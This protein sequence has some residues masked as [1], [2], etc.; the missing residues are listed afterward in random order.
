[1]VNFKILQKRKF[2]QES[3]PNV[4]QKG[5]SKATVI[6]RSDKSQS[7]AFTRLFY[8]LEWNSIHIQLRLFT[9][10]RSLGSAVE[11]GKNVLV[12]TE[13]VQ[14]DSGQLCTIKQRPR[15]LIH[16]HWLSI[17][18]RINNSLPL[19]IKSL[20]IIFKSIYHLHKILN[21]LGEVN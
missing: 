18:G 15:W 2:S 13:Q 11:N 10:S 1:M 16:P 4:V 14:I 17:V 3:D 20:T 6:G 21:C 8:R 9:M 12:P 5:K 19:Q 7:V